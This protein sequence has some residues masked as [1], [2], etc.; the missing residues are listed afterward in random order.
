MSVLS[1]AIGHGRPVEHPH[2][3]E[4]CP[5]C[6][7]VAEWVDGYVNRG[8]VAINGAYLCPDCDTCRECG[9]WLQWDYPDDVCYCPS[10]CAVEAVA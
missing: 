3:P 9:D 6:N 4:R 7:R 2:S 10:G 5:L 8:G 1:Y